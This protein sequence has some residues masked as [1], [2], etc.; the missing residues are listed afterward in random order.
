M[1]LL[2]QEIQELRGLGTKILNGEID[3]DKAKVLLGVYNQTAKRE[4]M[5]IQMAITTEKYGKDKSWKKLNNMNLMNDKG[6]ICA[7]DA[8]TDLMKCPKRGDLIITREDCL[9]YSG[10]ESHINACQ[11]CEQFSTTRKQIFNQ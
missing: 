3:N 9:D 7:E 1:G 8:T 10:T 5:L 2:E 6:V 11:Q 4:N